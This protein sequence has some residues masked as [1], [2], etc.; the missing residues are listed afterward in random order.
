MRVLLT[1]M[2]RGKRRRLAAKAAAKAAKVGQGEGLR[3]E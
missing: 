2:M 1:F 3:D